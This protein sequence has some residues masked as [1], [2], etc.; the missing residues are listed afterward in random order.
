V[1]SSFQQPTPEELK[2]TSDPAAP[3]APAVYLF[4]Q[5]ISD[6]KLHMHSLYVRI[7]I[8]TEK[9]KEYG[10]VEI[11]AYEGRIFSINGVKGRTI[12]S[13]GKVIPF[14]GKPI[15]KLLL[16]RGNEKV[17][18]K[19]FSL[20]DVQVGSII[21]YEYVLGYEDNIASSPRWYIQQ[22]LYVHKAHYHFVPTQRELTSNSEHGKVVNSLLYASILPPGVQVRSGMDGYDL[23]IENV[24]PMIDEEYMPPMESIS[25]RVLFYYSSYHNE[26]DFWKQEGKYWSKNVDRFAQPSA[27]LKAAVQQLTPPGDTEEQKLRKIYAAVMQ[28]ENASFTREHSAAENKAEGLKVKT[29]DDI[30]EQKRGNDDELTLLYIAMARAAGMKAYAMRVINR[31]RGLFIKNYMDWDQLDDDIAIVQVNGKEMFFDPG[32]RYCEFGKLHWKHAFAG[33]VRQVD[34]GT[35]IAESGALGYKDS[36]MLRIADLKLD[37]EDKLQGIIRMNFTGSEALRWRQDILRNDEEQAKK[38]FERELQKDMPAGVV[39]K[40]NHF[41]GANDYS[42]V[43][44]VIVDVS[45]GVGTSTG[46]RVFLPGAFFEANAKPL[47]VHEKRENPVDLHLPY[48]VRDTVTLTLPAGFTVESVPKD[49][50]IPLPNFADYVSK[51]KG[52]DTVYAYSR[53]MAVANIIYSAKEYAQIK[54][55][56]AKA[57]AQD[58]QQAVLHLTAVATAKGQ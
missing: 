40:T 25:Y 24:P 16:K 42:N 15:E 29:A 43:L 33:G 3:D 1:A 44:M 13:D 34:G 54:D 37:S 31:D 53:L 8:L 2:M 52:T 36:Q 30:W 58:Q 20:P 41:V 9:G 19:V 21:E 5:E 23:V 18:T 51:Y 55:F 26:D 35:A 4:R 11:P 10:D 57:N 46:K 32:E 22:P 47:F 39:V 6:D 48:M 7:K 17:M 14:T 27:K 50:E 45:G 56:Y 49:A 12:H 38:D 28:L